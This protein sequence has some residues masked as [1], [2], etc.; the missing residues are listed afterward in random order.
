MADLQNWIRHGDEMRRPLLANS[1]LPK[2]E[3]L[4]IVG[5]GL[6]GLCCALRIAEKRPELPIL[7]VEKSAELGGVIATWQ[8][9]EW[10]CDLAV[11]ATRP[12]PAFWRLIDDLQL[13]D[14]FQTSNPKAKSRWIL[15]D[16]KQHK[17]S[18]FSLLKIGPFK[19]RKALKLVKNGGYS[20]ADLIPNKQIA[21]ALTLGIVNDTAINVDADFL[22]PSVTKFGDN[23]PVKKSK[24]ASLVAKSYPLFTPKKGT[25]ASLDGGMITLTKA[26][27]ERLNNMSNVEIR[28]NYNAQSPKSVAAENNVPLSSIIWSA[29]G[30][31]DSYESTDLSIFAIGYEHQ[32]VAKVKLGYGTLIPNQSLPIS[33]ILH[34]SDIHQSKRSPSGHRLFR[35]MVPHSRWD[36]DES[37]VLACAEKLLANKPVLFTKIGERKIPRYKPGYLADIATLSPDFSMVGWAVSGVSITHVVDEAER[38][39]ELF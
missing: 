7:L 34:E 28:L 36:K 15:L 6:S 25:I 21:D 23:P 9:D 30:L 17:L 4:V 13:S 33:G 20:V 39:A 2:A 3:K 35:L 12:H 16:D 11:N 31:K 14:K 1:D 27:I 29:P 19:F 32:Q 22:M 37:S 38:V 10:I 26:L 24:L 18:P 8:E 5:G